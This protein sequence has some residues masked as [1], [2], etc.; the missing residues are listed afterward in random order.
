MAVLELTRQQARR[1]AVRA[2]LFDAEAAHLDRSLTDV[3]THLTRVQLDPATAVAPSADLV[4]WGRLGSAFVPRDLDD[5]LALG[6]V[7]NLLGM[8]R[9]AS[10]LA[11]FRAEMREWREGRVTGWRKAVNDWVQANDDARG[12][13]LDKLYDEG[14]LPSAEL[15]DTTAIPWR[16]G[17]W[18]D[19]RNLRML[20][21]ALVRRGEVAAVGKPARDQL[22]DLAERVYPDEPIV[23]IAEAEARL[24]TRRL[25]AQGIARPRGPA[26]PVESWDVA[27]CGE[28]AR[29]AGLRGLW[30]ID[31]SYLD[32]GF[33]GR[34]AL[35]SPI[36]LLVQDRKRMSELFEFDYTLEMFKPKAKRRW[37]YWAMPI[38][39]GD[40]LVGKLDATSD[41][42]AGVLI[43]NAVHEDGEWSATARRAVH[44]EI[45][46]LAGWLDLEL[47]WA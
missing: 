38:L 37:G 34:A 6:Q 42:R 22:W 26:S 35:L 23:P 20:L 16:S 24:E 13:V 25:R 10:D 30:R 40:R 47:V 29:V 28:P 2:Q 7:V 18:N 41:R 43:V 8:A 15:P 4:L 9:P 44:R 39:Y 33:R 31:P 5:A 32:G 11:L 17:G 1:I 19:D 21:G 27:A 36:D 46:A 14:P 3:V 45:R 12:D